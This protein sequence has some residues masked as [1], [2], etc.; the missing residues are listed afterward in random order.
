MN[1]KKHERD[2]DNMCMPFS[3]EPDFVVASVNY[4]SPELLSIRGPSR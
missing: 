3:L 4:R 2:L 1:A